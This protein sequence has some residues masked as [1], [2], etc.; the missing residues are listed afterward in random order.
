MTVPTMI[1][2]LVLALLVAG[3]AHFLDRALRSLGKPTRWIWLDAMVVAALALAR[4][5]SRRPLCVRYE[6][7]TAITPPLR[8]YTI[9]IHSYT[10]SIRSCRGY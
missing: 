7:W 3:A 9:N 2:G 5:F 8:L 4:R 6:A 1:Y 10:I